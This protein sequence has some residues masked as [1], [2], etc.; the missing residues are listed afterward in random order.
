M[1]TRALFGIISSL[2]V[3]FRCKY[4]ERI[5]AQLV[6]RADRMRHYQRVD[7][8]PIQAIPLS[9]MGVVKQAAGQLFRSCI[10]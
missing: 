8:E 7:L 5:V 1:D 6:A 2:G 10:A 3:K 4:C 9:R